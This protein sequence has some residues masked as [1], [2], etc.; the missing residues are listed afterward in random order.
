VFEVRYIVPG[1]LLFSKLANAE[2]PNKNAGF[3]LFLSGREGAFASRKIL[4]SA[5]RAISE[6][7]GAK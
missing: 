4:C 7:Q 2:K 5:G 6:D 1:K 3:S